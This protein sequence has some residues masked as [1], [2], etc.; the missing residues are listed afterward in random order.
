MTEKE[1]AAAFTAHLDREKAFR[2][3]GYLAKCPDEDA[4]WMERLEVDFAK[5]VLMTQDQQRR[6]HAII[7]EI[8]D[9]PWNQP[10]EGVHWLAGCGS[11]PN[12]SKADCHILGKR[13]EPGAPESGGPTFDDTVFYM[14]TCA[15]AFVSDKERAR[16]MKR[17]GLVES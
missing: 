14:E 16:V 15:R 4:S 7:S 5:P 17:R 11:K 13:P 1:A 3:G 6:L 12:W 2:E 9:S 8:V 10:K